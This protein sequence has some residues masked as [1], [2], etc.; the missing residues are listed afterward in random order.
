MSKISTFKIDETISVKLVNIL[1]STLK[2]W[3]LVYIV[4]K[5]LILNK[6]S[7][8]NIVSREMGKNNWINYTYL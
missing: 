7:F 8:G 2:R 1:V 3:V 5:M 4:K 6:F